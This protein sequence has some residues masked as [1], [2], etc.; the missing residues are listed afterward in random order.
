MES[1][2]DWKKT[3]SHVRALLLIDMIFIPRRLQVSRWQLCHLCTDCVQRSCCIVSGDCIV[4]LCVV[5]TDSASI[6][7]MLLT[8]S[9]VVARIAFQLTAIIFRDISTTNTNLIAT[10]WSKCK[11]RGGEWCAQ[12]SPL[13]RSYACLF[14]PII[15]TIWIGGNA[16]GHKL[17]V[18]K[19]LSLVLCYTLI[20]EL[21]RMLVS[22]TQ[23]AKRMVQ[24]I[25]WLSA[26][27]LL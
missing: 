12:V 21:R 27:E 7:L 2:G 16:F 6:Q 18:G 13:M 24:D 19:R 4:L 8:A 17:E 5:H 22:C 14:R 9:A 11:I 3:E 23:Y 25:Y 1:A 10:P 15:I 20:T 26:S